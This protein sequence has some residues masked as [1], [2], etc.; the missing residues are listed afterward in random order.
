MWHSLATCGGD[1]RALGFARIGDD[2]QQNEHQDNLDGGP[3]ISP[4]A[5]KMLDAVK[6]G[7]IL[8]ADQA[9]TK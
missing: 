2:R 6:P 8:S 5:I 1:S 3:H 4:W 7:G 9:I